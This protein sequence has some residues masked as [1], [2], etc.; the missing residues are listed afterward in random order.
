MRLLPGAAHFQVTELPAYE[1][2]GAGEHLY[3]LVE[4]EGVN[5]DDVGEALVRATGR[6]RRDVGY[7]GRK[8]RAAIARQWFSV[9]LADETSLAR[10]AA[11]AGGRIDVL[12]VA[13]H[14]NK[15][16]LGHL[17][18]NRFRLGLAGG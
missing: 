16:R 12:Q 15:L 1:P 4:K 3:V 9:R 7:A 6:E 11:P 5:S 13:R 10:L 18:G 14:R 8:D 17:H 2:S